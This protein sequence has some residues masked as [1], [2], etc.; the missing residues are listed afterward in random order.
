MIEIAQ[1]RIDR[2]GFEMLLRIA[3]RSDAKLVA[4]M[5]TDESDHF[6]CIEKIAALVLF[7]CHELRTVAAKCEQIV[8][9]AVFKKQERFFQIRALIA[10]TGHM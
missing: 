10:D 3:G 6:I 9:A 1:I 8:Q 7:I 2:L 5:L 4:V